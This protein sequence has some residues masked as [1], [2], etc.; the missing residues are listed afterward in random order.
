MSKY[1][2]LATHLRE[3]G[4]TVVSMTFD[5]IERVIGAALPASAFR[6]RAWWSNNPAN[7]VITYAWL[8][9]GYKTADVNMPGRKLVFRRAAQAGPLPKAGNGRPGRESAEAPESADVGF[10]SRVFGAL[11]GT[12]TT[13]PETDLTAPVGE[14]WDAAR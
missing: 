1:E 5:E 12:V 7:S 11:K 8:K 13:K 3:S 4:K 14:E 9:A 2:P 10:F 6:H